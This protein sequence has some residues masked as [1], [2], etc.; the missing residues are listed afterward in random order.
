MTTT[1]NA[2]FGSGVTVPGLG[3]VLNDEMDDFATV[4]G[5]ANMFGLVQGEPNAIAPGKRMLSS[6]S[7]TIVAGTRRAG[8]AR[9]RRRGRLAH[10]H[11]GLPGAL[12]RRRLRDGRRRRRARAALSP[13][14]FARRADAR[15][16]RAPRRGAP[17]ARGDGARDEGA[18][19]TSAGRARPSDAGP[20][21]SG[22][23]GRRRS[24][25][26][27]RPR[28][29]SAARGPRSIRAALLAARDDVDGGEDVSLKRSATLFAD[30]R[31][32]E[33]DDG[34]A[35]DDAPFSVAASDAT[36]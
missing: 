27:R 34:E 23:T 15:A 4:P 1:I 11:G 14:G 33:L 12:E 8:R 35:I 22:L 18:S 31:A 10:H 2:W 30:R 24:R 28:S 19:I 17:R 36:I 7:P 13:A 9:A 3:F 29:L 26:E 21:A 5:T 6:M 16:A 32:V 20:S 25:D